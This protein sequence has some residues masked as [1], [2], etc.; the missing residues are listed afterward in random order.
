M[1]T[2]E[3]PIPESVANLLGEVEECTNQILASAESIARIYD[4]GTALSELERF[5]RALQVV[6]FYM[7]R[8]EDDANPRE[9]PVVPCTHEPGNRKAP[10]A[11]P[12]RVMIAPEVMKQKADSLLISTDDVA[13]WIRELA[14]RGWSQRRIEV[15]F[16]FARPDGHPAAE[17]SAEQVRQNM[18]DM[19]D[20]DAAMRAAFGTIEAARQR[21]EPP[22]LTSDEAAAMKAAMAAAFSDVETEEP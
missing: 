16:G 13:A 12:E 19:D 8:V 9:I 20:I 5:V 21:R 17:P 1:T 10:A 22:P 15:A 18:R 4:E 3:K 11:E 6:T 7:M 2:S 14:A